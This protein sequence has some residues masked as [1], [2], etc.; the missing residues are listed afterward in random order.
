M[1]DSVHEYGIANNTERL[2]LNA[3]T[4]TSKDT[5]DINYFVK[6]LHTNNFMSFV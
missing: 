2:L 4:Q 5:H 6:S 1:C 3:G